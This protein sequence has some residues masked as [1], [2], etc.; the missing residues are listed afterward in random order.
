[1]DAFERD[2]AETQHYNGLMPPA[3]EAAHE[4]VGIVHG[5]MMAAVPIVL[6]KCDQF[7]PEEIANLTFRIAVCL[8]GELTQFKRE[9]FK[10]LAPVAEADPESYPQKKKRKH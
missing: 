3:A 10:T 5:F 9:A 4:Q 1:M 6:Q 7:S 2:D 8:T